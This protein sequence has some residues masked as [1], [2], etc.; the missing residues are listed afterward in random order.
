MSAPARPGDARLRLAVLDRMPARSQEAITGRFAR[1]FEVV[2]VDDDTPAA[3]I[4]VARDADVLLTMWG[5]LDAE[6]IA[7]ASQCRVIHKMG[8]GIEKIDT[9]AAAAHGIAVLR[10]AG[11]NADAVAELAVLLTLAVTRDLG[12]AQ[13]AARRE[14]LEKEVLRTRAVGLTGRTLGL[15]GFGDIGR[16]VAR[17]LTAFGMEIVYHDLVRADAA[18]EAACGDAR[19]VELDELLALADVVSLHLPVLPETI[20]LVDDDFLARMRS[21]SVLINTARGALVDEDALARALADGHLL[22]AGLD[23]TS[24]EPLDPASPLWGLDRVVITPHVGGAVGDNFPRVVDRV[25]DNVTAVLAGRPVPERD[26][27][28]PPGTRLRDG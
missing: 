6:V 3:K 25:H 7:A 13:A 11:I 23:V 18:T 15:L 24:T 14:T 8:V 21:G 22:G 5:R 1:Q 9:E 12:E 2:H 16:A 27:V 28:V 19:A 17:R 20:G 26:L 4:A 10:A